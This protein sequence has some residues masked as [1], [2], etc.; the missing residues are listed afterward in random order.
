MVRDRACFGCLKACGKF[1]KIKDS[2]YLG[3]ASEGPEYETLAMLGADCGVDNL[4]AVIYANLLCD[5]LG[6]D[7]ISTGNVIG[8]AMECYESNIFSKEDTDGLELSFG[9]YEAMID[10]I[11]KISRREGIGN[12]LADGVREASEKIGKGTE[13]FA[14]HIKGLEMPGWETRAIRGRGI[15][16]ATADRGACHLRGA[17]PSDRLHELPSKSAVEDMEGLVDHQN[18]RARA[19]SL[20]FCSYYYRD[21]EV[22]LSLITGWDWTKEELAK[23]GERIWNLARVLAV[24]EGI[25]REDDSVPYRIMYEPTPLGPA[26]G[27]RGFS[28]PNDLDKCLDKYYEIRGWDSDG[29]PTKEK[30]ADL[31]LPEAIKALYG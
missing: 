11:K 17:P 10:L 16:Y 14:M 28:E 2:P 20:V 26:K 30:L 4:N 19:N 23:A 1:V 5:Q 6:M 29:K 21:P 18:E 24:R 9:N 15:Q 25:S 27:C 8:F 12:L 3:M 22:A 31:E 7:T 13:R